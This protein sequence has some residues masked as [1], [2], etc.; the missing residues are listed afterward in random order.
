MWFLFSSEEFFAIFLSL[1]GEDK[2]L[3]LNFRNLGSL[4]EL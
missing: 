2:K 1:R 3:R 4:A